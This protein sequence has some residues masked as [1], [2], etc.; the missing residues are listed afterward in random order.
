MVYYTAVKKKKLF[1]SAPAWTDLANITLTE[2][3]QSLS[4]ES[5]EHNKQMNK[6]ETE[7]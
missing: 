7:A 2:I 3:S 1:P 5:N 4:V 6:T